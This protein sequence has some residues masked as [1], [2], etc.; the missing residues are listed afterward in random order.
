[1][2]NMD[3]MITSI[4]FHY[5]RLSF[6]S[7]LGTSQTHASL[8]SWISDFHLSLL[9]PIVAY[10]SLSSFY[11]FVSRK[12]LF[13]K[14]RIHTQ[15]E[16]E[17][18]NRASE[19]Q[20]AKSII[21]QQIMQTAWALLLGHIIF[22]VDDSPKNFEHEITAWDIWLMPHV[23]TLVSILGNPYLLKVGYNSR[24]AAMTLLACPGY[25]NPH[26][27]HADFW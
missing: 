14:Y 24:D 1:M 4:A 20:V 7:A 8:L 17:M 5:N 22:G 9:A 13:D 25:C 6:Q 26:T 12:G 10:W 16:Y 27:P 11:F 21:K 23:Q 19:W 2:G 3:S 18:R 15:T